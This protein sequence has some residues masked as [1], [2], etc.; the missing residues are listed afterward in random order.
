MAG[1]SKRFRGTINLC[2]EPFIYAV[3][4]NRVF[5]EVLKTEFSEPVAVNINKGVYDV[6]E[7]Y[8]FDDEMGINY[9]SGAFL[10]PSN[11]KVVL[12]DL[13]H[14]M[15]GKD[16][17]LREIYALSSKVVKTGEG[18][19]SNFHTDAYYSLDD[20]IA[21][22]DKCI[23]PPECVPL[24]LS[25]SNNEGGKFISGSDLYSICFNAGIEP[26]FNLNT[27]YVNSSHFTIDSFARFEGIDS[28]VVVIKNGILMLTSSQLNV[29]S[30]GNVYYV[31]PFPLELVEKYYEGIISVFS[32]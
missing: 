22:S 3:S 24:L 13:F 31:A 26:L 10:V 4:D 7:L 16:A 15:F 20:I 27:E 30:C 28:E 21:N 23:V 14:F 25:Y 8:Q 29:Y 2:S 11:E 6:Y 9:S 5:S 17:F 19:F 1:F 18:A 32:F 12:S